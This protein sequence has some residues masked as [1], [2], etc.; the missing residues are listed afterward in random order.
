MTFDLFMVWSN[1]CPSCYGNTGRLLHGIYKYAG[2]Q[3]VAHG[4]LVFFFFFFFL[5]FFF[6][7]DVFNV[8][9]FFF[10]FFFFRET[11]ADIGL[12]TV[13]SVIFLQLFRIIM[14]PD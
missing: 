3:I 14:V 10:V 2:E 6:V 7:F 8:V 12:Y 9:V 4:P 5:F 13:C 1:L 11:M